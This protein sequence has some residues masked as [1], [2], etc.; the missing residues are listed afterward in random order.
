MKMQRE[1]AAEYGPEAL[2]AYDRW[3]ELEA[4]YVKAI[5][6]QA[7]PFEEV[8]EANS[9]AVDAMYALRDIVDPQY[10]NSVYNWVAP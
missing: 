3:A 4:A 6:T 5:M 2:T 1:I 8:R 10:L 9:R 7:T